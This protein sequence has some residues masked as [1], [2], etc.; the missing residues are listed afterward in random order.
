LIARTEE[1]R[2]APCAMDDLRARNDIKLTIQ[3]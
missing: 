2:Y 3:R 1:L